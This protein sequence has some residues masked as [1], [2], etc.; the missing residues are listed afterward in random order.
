MTVTAAAAVVNNITGST[1]ADTF[2]LSGKMA[3]VRNVLDAGG[4]ATGT[5][6]VF[7]GTMTGTATDFT[8]FS[9][10]RP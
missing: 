5:V 8:S 1:K 3:D 9:G 6:D 7:N 2:T 4:S 10:L